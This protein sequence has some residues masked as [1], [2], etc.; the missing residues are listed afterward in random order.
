VYVTYG[1]IKHYVSS[2]VLAYNRLMYTT[3][4]NSSTRSVVWVSKSAMLMIYVNTSYVQ[5]TTQITN[6]I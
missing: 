4:T 3:P 6:K 5:H 2:V 1:H